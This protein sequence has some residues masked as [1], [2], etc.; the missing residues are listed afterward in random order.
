MESGVEISMFVL[1][2]MR[3][4]D[5]GTFEIDGDCS[6]TEKCASWPFAER[7]PHDRLSPAHALF[8]SSDVREMVPAMPV[9]EA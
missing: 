8:Q 9:V 3:K 2:P 4:V 6:W 7:Q 1:I 5:Q